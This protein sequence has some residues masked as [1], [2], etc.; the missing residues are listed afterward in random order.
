MVSWNHG[1]RASCLLPFAFLPFF[2]RG[3]CLGYARFGPQWPAWAHGNASGWWGL[4]GDVGKEEF[5]D[6]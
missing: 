3:V 1:E 6:N 4:G 2:F 5:N